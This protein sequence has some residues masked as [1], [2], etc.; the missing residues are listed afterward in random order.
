MRN[1]KMILTLALVMVLMAF[2]LSVEAEDQVYKWKMTS[3][4]VKGDNLTVF[5]ERFAKLVEEKSG[6]RIEIEVFP[7]GTLGSQLDII[8][9]VQMG[10]AQIAVAS[11]ASFARFVP[12]TQVLS[13]QY[14]WPKENSAMVVKEVFQKGEAVKLLGEKYKEKGFHLLGAWVAAWTRVTSK[15]PIKSPEDTKGLKHRVM[16]SPILVKAYNKYGFSAQS[17]N[18]GEVYGALQTKL[19]DS[20]VN[21]NYSIWAMSFFEVQDYITNLWNEL[22]TEITVIN[23]DAFDSLPEDLQKIVID[24]YNEVI[25]LHNAWIFQFDEEAARKI[26]D[27]KPTI[28]FYELTDEEIVPFKELAWEKDGAAETY[29]QIGGEGAKE[30]LDALLA[31]IKKVTQ[32]Q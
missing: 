17:L 27:A 26:K 2:V 25:S 12:Q 24:S 10:Q 14:L 30:I 29:L 13:L 21:P 11:T 7:Q 23:N 8:E 15:V 22:H 19:I 3:P 4:D 6:G 9:I 5:G 16:A 20:Q 28:T 18:Y 32:K 1:F 31:D